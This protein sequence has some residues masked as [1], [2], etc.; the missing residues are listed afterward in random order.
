MWTVEILNEDSN[1]LDD[2]KYILMSSEVCKVGRA[3]DCDI[4]ILNDKSIS[5]LRVSLNSILYIFDGFLI[6]HA[7]IMQSF[8]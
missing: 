3:T 4:P 7:G 1:T 8:I 6:I 5:R 2:R